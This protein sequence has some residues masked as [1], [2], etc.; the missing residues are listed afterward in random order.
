M[1]KKY[2][3]FALGMFAAAFI[4]V[5]TARLIRPKVE[6]NLETNKFDETLVKECNC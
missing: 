4:G 6:W 2:I 5:A 1:K 3:I